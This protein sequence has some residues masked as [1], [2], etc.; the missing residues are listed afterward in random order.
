MAV[1]RHVLT[2]LVRS[3]TVFETGDRKVPAAQNSINALLIYPTPGQPEAFATT[4]LVA[5]IEEQTSETVVLVVFEVDQE[6]EDFLHG[7]AHTRSYGSKS[8]RYSSKAKR[9]VMP[10]M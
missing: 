4:G 2:I 1:P 10:A 9:S 8:F 6:I 3:I 5:G 7:P